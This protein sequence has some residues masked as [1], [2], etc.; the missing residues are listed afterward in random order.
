MTGSRLLL[1]PPRTGG[2]R[3]VSLTNR[4][5]H[6]WRF[7]NAECSFKSG[8]IRSAVASRRFRNCARQPSRR[9]SRSRAWCPV[10]YWAAPAPLF[11]TL[12][13][14]TESWGADRRRGFGQGPSSGDGSPAPRVAKLVKKRQHRTFG[15]SAQSFVCDRTL[16]PPDDVWIASERENAGAV[17]ALAQTTGA[18]ST[19]ARCEPVNLLPVLNRHSVWILGCARQEREVWRSISSVVRSARG[20]EDDRGCAYQEAEGLQA[21]PAFREEGSGEQHRNCGIESG[22]DGDDGELS[23]TGGG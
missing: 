15:S 5:A 9:R 4:R 23:V 19:N 3:L 16:S 18:R 20:D 22:Q 12:R 14:Q 17:N 11:V 13:P 7:M 21:G 6:R 10:G 8:W 2:S 1:R